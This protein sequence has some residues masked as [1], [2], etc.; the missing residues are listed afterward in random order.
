MGSPDVSRVLVRA[1]EDEALEYEGRPGAGLGIQIPVRSALLYAL[2]EAGSEPCRGLLLGYLGNTS[3]SVLGGFYL[4]AMDAL[5]KFG[6]SSDLTGL[7]HG[8]E[9]VAANAIGV[10]GALGRNEL[11][12]PALEDPRQRVSAAARLALGIEPEEKQG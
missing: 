6:P 2:G 5:I 3:G 11:V 10:L 9:L 4:P 1:L 12:R 8:P 7:L